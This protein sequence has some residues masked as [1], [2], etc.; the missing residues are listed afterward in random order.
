MNIDTKILAKVERGAALTDAE[1]AE[2]IRFYTNMA[3]GL[4]A[5]GPRFHFP[6]AHCEH[7]L[8]M[9]RGFARNRDYDK[10]QAEQRGCPPRG[11]RASERIARKVYA[12]EQR[13]REQREREST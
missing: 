7:T 6:W 3:S 5:L 12:W 2:A 9:L 4:A 13:A 10:Q 8:E 1:L 11:E